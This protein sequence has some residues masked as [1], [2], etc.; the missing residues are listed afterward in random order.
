MRWTRKTLLA[1]ALLALVGCGGGG[2]DS[3]PSG[4]GSTWEYV[5]VG[6]SLAFGIGGNRGYV[7]RY[8]DH[9]VLDTDH[10][11][12]VTNLGVPGWTSA[13]LF[14]AVRT[15]S[16]FRN[17]I[18]QAEVV[19]WNI[20]GNDLLNALDR[21][22]NN[23]CG[24]GDNLECFRA[25]VISFRANWDGIV[26]EIRSLRSS[27]TTIIRTMDVYN[28]FVASLKANGD[29]EKLKP[30]LD[31]MNAHIAQSA[32]ANEIP[33]ARVYLAFNGANGDENAA[34]KGYLSSDQ[35]HPDD[36][37]YAK[38]AELLRGLGYAPLE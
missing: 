34:A 1:F 26:A 27:G 12:N 37:G 2:S 36:D 29:L 17:A 8:R 33:L 4:G 15:D 14:T 3:G 38:I 7:P 18:G 19:T 10:Q 9:I 22:L 30:F 5:A 16:G 21:Y 32:Q 25:T 20:G 24:G 6:D 23:T 31:E 13:D 35:V 11:V 28:P